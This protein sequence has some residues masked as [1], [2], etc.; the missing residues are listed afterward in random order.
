[1]SSS[2]IEVKE[3]RSLV[4][5]RMDRLPWARFHWLIVVGLGF[6]WILDGLEVQIVAANGYAQTLGMGS[7]EVGLAG[8]I[9]LVGQVV[10]ALFFGRLADRLG[11]RNLFI[12][13][14]GIYLVG[15]AVAGLA[16]APWFFYV[17][18]F[19]AGAGI[20]GE[21]AAI[22]SAI[23][24]IIPSKYR[25]RVDVAINGTYWAG[26]AL[27]AVASAFFLNPAI[28]PQ[29]LGWRLSFFIG[30]ILGLLIIYLRRH[31]PE[32]PRWQMTHGREAE[33]E[34]NVDAIEERIRQEGKEI[35][36]VDE[37]KAIT[38]RE[39]GRVP[40]LTIAS[41]LF[42][43]YPR[44]T[45]VGVTMMVTQSFLYN[46]IFFT[47]ALVLGNF[48]GIP[49]EN[50]S[51][52]FIVFAI[53]NLLGALCLGHFFDTWGRRRMIFGTYVVAGLVL[54][55]SAFLF[56]AGVLNALTQTIFWC[57]SFFFASAG[58]SAA[59]LTVSEIFPLELRSQVISY[60]F[61]VGQLVGAVA[62]V[63]YGALIGDGTSREPL[64]WGYVI[65]SVV[66]I[67]GGVIA[68]VFGVSAAGKSLEDVAD[69]LSLV[70]K[71]DEG[72]SPGAEA[73]R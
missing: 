56:N 55:V 50:A 68:G 51:I 12:I 19:I 37:S 9:Y 40:F 11:R 36:P 7:V 46:A 52:Y 21:Y 67:F 4:P 16:F 64:F 44:R 69:P 6:S 1:M 65:G 27:G 23:D 49:P 72:V 34:R 39:Y 38:V 26:A 33:A 31:I 57:V 8:T 14:L 20:G 17:F 47:Y 71:P 10:G 41:V 53:G 60:V 30:P 63:L 54:L 22:N 48:Y 59:Y 24:E 3:V 2:K 35:P 70:A 28:F 42:R 25:G 45:L 18:R 62:P 66:M 61:S 5:A 13:S 29:D 58:A 32:S 15:S 43:K 73:K